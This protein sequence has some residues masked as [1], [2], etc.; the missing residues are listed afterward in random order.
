MRVGTLTL[1][2]GYNEGAILQSLALT[3][4]VKDVRPAAE[5]EI[6]DHR[7]PR[8]VEKAYGP[9]DNGRKQALQAFGDGLPLSPERF[10]S[11]GSRQTWDYA[12]ARYDAV[13]VGSDE[14]WKVVYRQRLKGLIKLQND[15]Y[16]PAFPNIFWPDRSVDAVKIGYAATIGAKTNWLALPA[17]VKRMMAEALESFKAI[18]VRDDRTFD[19]IGRLS[20]ALQQKAVLTPDPTFAH[21]LN[22]Y[23][24]QDALR[25]KFAAHG[26]DFDRPRLLV[27][28]RKDPRCTI[29][30]QKF[31][32]AGYQTVALSEANADTDIDLSGAAFDPLEWAAAASLFDACLSERMHGCIFSLLNGTPVISLDFRTATMGHQT[33]NGELYKRTGIPAFNVNL[34]SAASSDIETACNKVIAGEWPSEAV[35]NRIAEYRRTGTGFLSTNLPQ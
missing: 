17:K 2:S 4:A 14:V 21:P 13:L 32:A 33:K 23:A 8:L 20:P 26:V 31:K 3:H 7:F 18:G 15:P 9:A 34:A 22:R 6:V 29:A 30:L 28:A 12:S 19:F 11:S 1:H 35:E 24:D 27:I 25:A 10:V 16:A 5:V